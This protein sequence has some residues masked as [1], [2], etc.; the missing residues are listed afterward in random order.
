MS[1]SSQPS[2]FDPNRP[3]RS[4]LGADK[5][6]RLV[7]GQRQAKLSSG[8]KGVRVSET[9]GGT[10]ISA[11]DN[12][13]RIFIPQFHIDVMGTTAIIHPGQI[14]I[15]VHCYLF[16]VTGCGG[17]GYSTPF[18]TIDRYLTG[19]PFIEIPKVGGLALT[20]FRTIDDY[21]GDPYVTWQTQTDADGHTHYVAGAAKVE[22]LT[23]GTWNDP[24]SGMYEG[25]VTHRFKIGR[26]DADLKRVVEQWHNDVSY[27]HVQCVKGGSS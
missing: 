5:L 2:E 26:Y 22:F 20:E 24:A 12:R 1:D 21:S 14:A 11:I 19:Q 8:N 4:E 13:K 18:L 10:T 27:T 25:V 15:T 7:R 6:N 9:A 23:D 3:A 17:G 16:N